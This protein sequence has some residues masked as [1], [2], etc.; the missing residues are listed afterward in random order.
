MCGCLWPG[1][2]DDS[3]WPGGE[4]GIFLEGEESDCVLRLEKML[5]EVRLLTFVDELN[6]CIT[7]FLPTW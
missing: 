1:E 2:D 6:C 7:W 5:N 3:G 4:E